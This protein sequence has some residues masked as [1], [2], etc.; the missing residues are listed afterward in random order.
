MGTPI[1]NLKAGEEAVIIGLVGSYGFQRK[2]RTM[3]IIEGKTI[4]VLAKQPFSGPLVVEIDG[5]K[6]TIGRGMAQRI[7]VGVEG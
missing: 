3:G 7:I 5:R 6:T 1:T 2:L 4:K